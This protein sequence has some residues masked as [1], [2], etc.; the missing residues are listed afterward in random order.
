MDCVT[1]IC[2]QD[3]VLWNEWIYKPGDQPS[4]LLIR[5]NLHAEHQSDRPSE[6][7]VQLI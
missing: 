3:D 5:N 7:F 2:D 6:R 4:A 1:E